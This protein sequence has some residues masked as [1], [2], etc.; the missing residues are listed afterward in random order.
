MAKSLLLRWAVERVFRPN[1][2]RFSTIIGQRSRRG[3]IYN[4]INFQ[5]KRLTLALLH[6]KG[7]LRS[8]SI[9]DKLKSLYRCLFTLPSRLLNLPF[10]IDCMAFV[11][12]GWKPSLGCIP[13]TIYLKRWNCH[14]RCISV[15]ASGWRVL[16]SSFL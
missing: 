6:Y 12:K 15:A 14:R 9:H 4:R 13:W 1:L 10:I 11:P 3:Q 5:R 8:K 2:W 7:L 16:P